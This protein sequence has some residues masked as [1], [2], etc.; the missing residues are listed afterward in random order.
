MAV[1]W[2]DGGV[3][4]RVWPAEVTAPARTNSGEIDDSLRRGFVCVRRLHYRSD[5]SARM[6]LFV[7]AIVSHDLLGIIKRLVIDNKCAESLK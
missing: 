4:G 2:R 1:R 7:Y 6:A 3:D 5:H